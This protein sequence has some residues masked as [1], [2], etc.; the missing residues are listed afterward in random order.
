MVDILYVAKNLFLSTFNITTT[1]GK[2]DE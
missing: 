2:K 1:K